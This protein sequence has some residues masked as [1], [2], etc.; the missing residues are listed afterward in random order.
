VELANTKEELAA[1]PNG[2]TLEIRGHPKNGHIL[3]TVADTGMGIPEEVKAK[4]FTPMMTTKA[5]GQGF[6]LAVSK[7][8]IEALKGT[9]SFESEPGKGTKFHIELPMQ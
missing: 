2:G 8:L 4:L 5:K 7:R 9:I 1:M 6:G 3:I